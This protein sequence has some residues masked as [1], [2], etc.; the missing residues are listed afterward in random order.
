MPLIEH[1]SPHVPMPW[2]MKVAE[3]HDYDLLPQA[4]R[5]VGGGPGECFPS[6][7]IDWRREGRT[8]ASPPA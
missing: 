5:P 2:P 8:G 3:T 6:L 7:I 4:E 1:P